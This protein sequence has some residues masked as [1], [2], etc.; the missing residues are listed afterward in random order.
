MNALL[1]C[2]PSRRSN[3][4]IRIT[5]SSQVYCTSNFDAIIKKFCSTVKAGG[6]K[7]MIYASTSWLNNQLDMSKLSGYEVWVAQYYSKVTYGGTYKCWQYSSTGSVNGISG[8]VDMDY[9]YN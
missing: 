8:N 9:W 2:E 7:P 1:I 3:S 5:P 6:Y 4:E